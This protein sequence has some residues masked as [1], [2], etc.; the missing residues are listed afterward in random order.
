VS[1]PHVRVGSAQ[2]R[3]YG[4]EGGARGDLVEDNPRHLTDFVR[5][6]VEH[7]AQDLRR[8]HETRGVRIHRH[9]AC[10]EA[11][12]GALLGQRRTQVSELLV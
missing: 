7:R 1:D 6:A 2:T 10:H 9:V 11:N 4:R 8:H 12:R 3:G 5:T